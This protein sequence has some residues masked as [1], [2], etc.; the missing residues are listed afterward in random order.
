MTE[1]EK[2]DDRKK[3]RRT[4]ILVVIGF[5][6]FLF[7][8]VKTKTN[9]LGRSSNDT[10]IENTDHTKNSIQE[11]SEYS[12]YKCAECGTRCKTSSQIYSNGDAMSNYQPYHL[13]GNTDCINRRY[14]KDLRMRKHERLEQ[15]YR[16]EMRQQGV[17]SPTM[18]VN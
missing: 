12:G 5:A 9:L 4:M 17:E 8:Q 13:C 10:M 3:T 11:V 2:L 16:D 1:Q 7:Y 14:E 18:H 15:N 6:M